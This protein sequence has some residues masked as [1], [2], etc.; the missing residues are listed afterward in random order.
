MAV[1]ALGVA[2]SSLLGFI[3]CDVLHIMPPINMNSQFYLTR[4]VPIGALSASA[5]WLSNTL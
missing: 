3:V 1:A 2:V 4:V 5:L